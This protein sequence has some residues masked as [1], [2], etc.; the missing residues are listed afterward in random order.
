MLASLTVP[1][2][3]GDSSWLNWI[4][5]A[6]LQLTLGPLVGIAFGLVGGWIFIHAH[7]KHLTGEAFEGI[8]AI[9]LAGATYLAAEMIGGNGFIAAFIAGLTFAN[10]VKGQCRFVYEFLESDGQFLTWAAFFLIGFALLPGAIS[11][12]TPAIAGLIVTSLIVVRPLAI[13]LSLAGTDASNPTKLFVGWFG[14]RGLATALFA[15][16][17]VPIAEHELAE[18]VLAIAV[19]A[20]WISAV[21]HGVTASPLAKWFGKRYSVPERQ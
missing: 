13:W 10:R 14:P 2:M 9:S 20:V 4:G 1:M 6:A 21:L 7:Q 16:L 18:Q 5:V 11:H 17:V 8:A 19:N 3:H 15:L 12:L